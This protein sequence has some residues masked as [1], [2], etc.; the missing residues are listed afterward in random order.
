MRSGDVVVMESSGGGG[1]GDPT[2][3]ETARVEADMID[4]YVSETGLRS[5]REQAPRVSLSADSKLDST[6]CRLA[7]DIAHLLRAAPGDL[8]ELSPE[9]G[10]SSRFWITAIDAALDPGVIAIPSQL[11]APAA[12]S[13]RLLSSFSRLPAA[14][15]RSVL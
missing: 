10:P 5:Y 15:L 8:I 3:R 13:I 11:A 4:G 14:T 6:Q 2:K 1:Y 12:V 7:A 9:L